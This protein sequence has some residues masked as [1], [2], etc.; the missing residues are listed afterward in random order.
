MFSVRFNATLVSSATDECLVSCSH[1][2]R[3]TDE[4]LQAS[5]GE[6]KNCGESPR[7]KWT[8]LHRPKPTATYNLWRRLNTVI[9]VD[10][11]RLGEVWFISLLGVFLCNNCIQFLSNWQMPHIAKN[12]VDLEYK[13]VTLLNA[14]YCTH[15]LGL[16][17]LLCTVESHE[18]THTH[19]HS[20]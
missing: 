1:R 15:P 12:P 14:L 19:T 7:K 4:L 16:I 13:N 20:T 10:V 8:P 9:T 6:K 17:R 3:L 11:Y 18:L 5:F 2:R